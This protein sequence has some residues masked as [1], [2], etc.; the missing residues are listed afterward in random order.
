MIGEPHPG[1]QTGGVP[2][3][4]P[5]ELRTSLAN[6]LL[7][8][9]NGLYGTAARLIASSRCCNALSYVEQGNPSSLTVLLGGVPGS[10][11]IPVDRAVRVVARVT[12]QRSPRP[13]TGSRTS[14]ARA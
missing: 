7:L 5:L 1:T 11:W 13:F 12:Y 9:E 4:S 6:A 10:Q 2:G 14:G 8:V 3:F